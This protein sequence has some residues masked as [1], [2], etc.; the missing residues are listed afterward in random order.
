MVRQRLGD[1]KKI[2]LSRACTNRRHAAPD[3][4]AEITA[5]AIDDCELKPARDNP[6]MM[7]DAALQRGRESTGAMGGDGTS[8]SGAL[9]VPNS[10]IGTWKSLRF[11]SRYSLGTLVRRGRASRLAHWRAAN[12]GYSACAAALIRLGARRKNCY[13]D[14]CL[15]I[16]VPRRFREPDRNHLRGA[17]LPHPQPHHPTP[18]IL[19]RGATA[20]L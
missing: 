17:V 5:R 12:T 4:F 9:T 8:R 10:G 1:Y 3:N 16:G 2:L 15:A 14:N 6:P 18:L 7:R 20:S 13:D 11:S 19:D